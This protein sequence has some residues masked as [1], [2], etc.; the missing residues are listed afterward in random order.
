MQEIV[1]AQEKLVYRPI[2][3]LARKVISHKLKIHKARDEAMHNFAKDRKT[4]TTP[5]NLP[6]PGTQSIVS[7]N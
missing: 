2:D 7:R 6:Q 1:H 5:N 3:P 4:S